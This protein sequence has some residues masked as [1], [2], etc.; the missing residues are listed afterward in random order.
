[1]LPVSVSITL[2]ALKVIEPSA[3]VGALATAPQLTAGFA[4]TLPMHKPSAQS[5]VLPHGSPSL[6][7]ALPA[8]HLPPLHWSGALQ[9][10][11]SLQGALLGLWVQAPVKASQPSLVHGLAS[12]QFLA[13]PV[14]WH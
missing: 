13:V 11:P 1:M 10:L 9:A 5:A 7:T 4:Q 14:G 12:S 3:P 2:A 8:A 6:Q